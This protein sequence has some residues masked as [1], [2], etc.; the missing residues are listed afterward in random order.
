MVI[1]DEG[2]KKTDSKE[3]TASKSPQDDT[4][5]TMTSA[6]Q[7]SSVEI[8]KVEESVKK[9]KIDVIVEESNQPLHTAGSILK[10]ASAVATATLLHPK[11]Q[12]AIAA[13]KGY[14]L[15]KATVYGPKT[16]SSIKVPTGIVTKAA[17]VAKFVSRAAPIVSALALGSDIYTSKKITA[18]HVLTGLTV[19]ASAA[20]VIASAP[21]VVATAA[22]VATVYLI[23]TG[24]SLLFTGKSLEENLNTGLDKRGATKHGGTLFSW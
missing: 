2:S 18:G 5:K 9:N 16:G 24:V 7:S 6:L 13:A 10:K 8:K 3:T 21:V 15:K 4:K 22:V 17:A 19:V 20:A 11:Q 1:A 12:S 14:A 23:G